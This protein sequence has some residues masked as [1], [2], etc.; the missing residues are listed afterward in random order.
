[1]FKNDKNKKIIF[2]SAKNSFIGVHIHEITDIIFFDI[3]DE[4]QKDIISI[5]NRIGRNKELNLHY[6]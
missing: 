1:M 5:A 6:F 3:R 4:N 2:V